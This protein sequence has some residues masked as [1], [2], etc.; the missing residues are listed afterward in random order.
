MLSRRLFIDRREPGRCDTAEA[1]P[2]TTG[3]NAATPVAIKLIASARRVTPLTRSETS[4]PTPRPMA[5]CENATTP[6]TGI[7]S[8]NLS[9]DNCDMV[10][11][12]RT[13]L[14]DFQSK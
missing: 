5:T 10:I 6:E 9:R 2:A 13:A 4:N 8:P 1:M 3:T 12:A 14:W 11:E 7:F